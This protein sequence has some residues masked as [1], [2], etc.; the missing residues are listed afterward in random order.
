MTKRLEEA[1][2]L[3]PAMEASGP[4]PSTRSRQNFRQRIAER[5][6]NIDKQLA[7]IPRPLKFDAAGVG[8][9]P[10]RRWGADAG[11]RQGGVFQPEEAGRARLHIRIEPGGEGFASYRTTVLLPRGTHPR[12]PRTNRGRHGGRHQ[13]R[14]PG[15]R[16]SGSQPQPFDRQCGLAAGR[17]ISKSRRIRRTWCW[18][19]N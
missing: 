5:V 9:P 17:L 14:R 10:A 15:L 12:R 6:K 13:H 1:A 4:P 11:R 16:I 2:R 19:A 3:K 18:S 7:E 8:R